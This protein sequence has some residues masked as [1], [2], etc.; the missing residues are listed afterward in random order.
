MGVC[1]KYLSWKIKSKN[2]IL[3]DFIINYTDSGIERDIIVDYYEINI[4]A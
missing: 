1:F 2:I 4:G 3:N